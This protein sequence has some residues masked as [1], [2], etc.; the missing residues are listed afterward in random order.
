MPLACDA[1]AN[2]NYYSLN[3]RAHVVYLD[4]PVA[5]GYSFGAV[6]VETREEATEIMRKVVVR[7][8]DEF[9]WYFRNGIIAWDVGYGGA[10]AT[11]FTADVL[12]RN[13]AKTR[14]RRTTARTSST[15]TSTRSSSYTSWSSTA[16][17]WT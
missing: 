13:A 12:R 17:S 7:L 16:R 5:S 15:T 11:A 10:L 2:D 4:G 14:R 1:E 8:A 6:N 9:P 3:S